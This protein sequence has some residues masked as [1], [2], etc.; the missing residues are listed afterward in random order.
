MLFDRE[1]AGVKIKGKLSQEALHL[2][3]FFHARPIGKARIC[4]TTY[5]MVRD[6]YRK[7]SEVLLPRNPRRL[8]YRRPKNWF[9]RE[10]SMTKRVIRIYARTA[11]TIDGLDIHIKPSI[12]DSLLHTIVGSS[13]FDT[14][15]TASGLSHGS[16]AGSYIRS[17]HFPCGSTRLPQRST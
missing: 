14:Q 15:A 10:K 12:K 9:A 5:E 17:G 7:A 1:S 2:G 3:S 13:L 11:V 8:T 16:E 4:A 6:G